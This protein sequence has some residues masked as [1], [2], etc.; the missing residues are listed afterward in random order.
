MSD[1]HTVQMGETELQVVTRNGYE[2]D[3]WQDQFAGG[4][5]EDTLDFV[6]RHVRPG[7]AFLDIGA[8][9]GPISLCAASLGARVLALEPDPLAHAAITENVR[10]NADRL[11]GS[12]EVRQAAFNATPGEVRI[13]STQGGFGTSASS[14][15]G[16]GAESV[17]VPAITPDEIAAWA[18][19]APTVMKV[20][21]EAHEFFC[22]EALARLRALTGSALH[23]SAH[24]KTLEKSMG[25]KRW[26]GR[27]KPEARLR[28]RTLLSLFDGCDFHL[29][30]KPEAMTGHQTATLV[31]QDGGKV[32]DFSVEIL[33][34][35][36]SA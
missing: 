30:G 1:I 5:E 13:F 14:S 8:W 12:I 11:P 33:P 18:G 34:R 21:I 20:D 28:T 25:W 29:P 10:L 26:L 4:W 19:D 6:R 22:G 9:I 31:A 36:A 7:S 32:Y 17:T 16:K 35:P 27:A 2:R 23:L 3:F 15:V 24:P